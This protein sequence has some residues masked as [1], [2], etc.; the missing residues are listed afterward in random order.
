MVSL[1][2]LDEFT[3]KITEYLDDLEREIKLFENNDCSL[4]VISDEL[5][6]LCKI[7]KGF[8]NLL[9]GFC[10]GKKDDKFIQQSLQKRISK[11]RENRNNLVRK[12]QI[13]DILYV[14]DRKRVKQMATDYQNKLVTFDKLESFSELEKLEKKLTYE[15]LFYTTRNLVLLEKYNIKMEEMM[16]KGVPKC[17][18]VIKRDIL[19][20]L[21]SLY[22]ED[23]IVSFLSFSRKV[24]I[25]TIQN[26]KLKIRNLHD[27]I[28]LENDSSNKEKS[29]FDNK[30][31]RKKNKKKKKKNQESLLIVK[32]QAIFRKKRQ[33]DIYQRI[34]MYIKI[35]QAKCRRLIS[36]QRY[37]H[38]KKSVLLIQKEVP[39]RVIYRNFC[40]VKKKI[41]SHVQKTQF[42]L[43][44]L[45]ESKYNLDFLKSKFMEL[46][47]L[48]YELLMVCFKGLI[49]SLNPKNWIQRC[50]VMIQERHQ[51]KRNFIMK[52]QILMIDPTLEEHIISKC[53]QECTDRVN[54]L[55]KSNSKSKK[56]NLKIGIQNNKMNYLKKKHKLLLKYH[57]LK[58][59]I[60][61][62]WGNIQEEQ[63]SDVNRILRTFDCLELEDLCVSFDAFIQY[64]RLLKYTSQEKKL[65]QL[66]ILNLA[67]KDKS[68][69]SQSSKE[70]RLNNKKEESTKPE[71]VPDSQQ[72]E[73]NIQKDRLERLEKEVG[74]FFTKRFTEVY[75]RAASGELDTYP[76]G[77]RAPFDIIGNC[78]FSSEEQKIIYRKQQQFN[79]G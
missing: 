61:S 29:C 37:H 54:C 75:K 9:L 12:Y 6:Q 3:I 11:Y 60:N 26:L 14:S 78:G 74:N 76:H 55:R 1:Q 38:I 18:S 79:V 22:V 31:R 17:D 21:E 23:T 52:H 15:L 30:K 36:Q 53:I 24:S 7:K 59:H 71:T 43:G 73:L 35:V 34:L 67:S 66:D 4:K 2:I 28:S 16:I 8:L 33:R 20:N 32:I 69:N 62:M 56:N 40:L 49:Y 5:L 39:F 50:D 77:K 51:N 48:K 44:F 10:L 64:T 19:V 13:E 46:T 70:L 41:V 45:R 68:Q 42:E 27:E 58:Q 63:L 25:V 57:Y 72:E 47:Q 65:D